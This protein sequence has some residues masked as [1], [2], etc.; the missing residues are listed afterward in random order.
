MKVNMPDL[1]ASVGLAQIRK[2]RSILLPERKKIFDFYTSNFKQYD[3][4][5]IPTYEIG[6]TVSSYHLYLLRIKGITEEQRDRMIDIISKDGVGVNVHYTPMPMLTL[7]KN[8]GYKM[9]DYPKTFELYQNEI[10]LP[11]YN[12]LTEEQLKRVV[13][14]VVKAYDSL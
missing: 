7:F 1:C 11:V 13:K 2:Y 12:G 8:R 3:W 5:I 9:Q 14:V 4:A 6:A 10:T